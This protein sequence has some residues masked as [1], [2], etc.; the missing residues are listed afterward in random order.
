MLQLDSDQ[1]VIFLHSS[2]IE[3]SFRPSISPLGTQ[4]IELYTQFSFPYSPLLY[5]SCKIPLPSCV[6]SPTCKFWPYWR[7]KSPSNQLETSYILWEPPFFSPNNKHE[8]PTYL[9]F[10]AV[11]CF[12]SVMTS[13]HLPFV[14]LRFQKAIVQQSH[15]FVISWHFSSHAGM[16]RLLCIVAQETLCFPFTSCLLMILMV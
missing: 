3:N 15:G 8:S 7:S 14:V 11:S 10:M 12:L 1:Q 2:D 16:I 5:P 9:Y 13:G 4:F 6:L